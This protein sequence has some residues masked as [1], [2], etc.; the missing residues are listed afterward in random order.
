MSYVYFKALLTFSHLPHIAGYLIVHPP[1][2]D[3]AH[4]HA[5]LFTPSQFQE[6]VESLSTPCPF[7]PVTP[8]PIKHFTSRVLWASKASKQTFPSFYSS[9]NYIFRSTTDR[10]VEIRQAEIIP[11]KAARI[12]Q[13]T[14]SNDRAAKFGHR[15]EIHNFGV[16]VRGRDRIQQGSSHGVMGRSLR[17][18]WVFIPI[19]LL[20]STHKSTA[21]TTRLATL[22]TISS[23][24][25]SR[26]S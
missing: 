15:D 10:H 12:A 6:I 3:L 11:R 20:I 16:G 2:L 9:I 7:H 4:E 17:N 24:R 25:P 13:F 19:T 1:V 21:C 26:R 14:A 8:P 23:N 5:I 22:P 18:N